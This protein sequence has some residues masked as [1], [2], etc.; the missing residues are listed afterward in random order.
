MFLDGFAVAGYRSF[1]PELQE[2]KNLRKINMFV[3]RNNSGKSNV[4]RFA[5][6]LSEIKLGGAYT[7]FDRFLDYNLGTSSGSI[8]AG[9]QVKAGPSYS[10]E[11]FEAMTSV[12]PD[13]GSVLPEYSEEFWITFDVARPHEKR[14]YPIFG[15]LAAGI[16]ANV[17]AREADH[18]TSSHLKYSGGDMRKKADD[19]AEV[20]LRKFTYE[21]SVRC[22]DA[23]RR[24]SGDEESATYSG[25]GLIRRLR[26]L[27]N[28]KLEDYEASTEKFA[29]INNFIQDLTGD[30]EAKME[31][32]AESEEIYIHL[33]GRRL[34]LD[35]LGTGIHQLVI[36]AS[37]VTIEENCVF[38]IEEPEIHLHPSLQKKLIN[39]IN[40]N[41]NNQYLIATHSN[42]F[43]DLEGVGVYHCYLSEGW[44][45]CEA[46]G[47]R[48]QGSR[49]LSDLGYRASD[50]LQA[51]F[52]VWVEGPSDRVL[53]RH[54][55]RKVAP[56]LVEGV[57]YSLMFYGGRL[58]SHLAFDDADVEEFI[59]LCRLNTHAAIIMD[60]DLEAAG[61]KLGRTK[62][63]VKADFEAVDCLTWVTAGRTIENYVSFPLLA[64]AYE[65]V[66]G[67]VPEEPRDYRYSDLTR[68]GETSRPD[69][70]ALARQVASLEADLEILD[71]AAQIAD[72]AS[73][74]RA[75][76]A[77]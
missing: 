62:L 77:Y 15:D 42:A 11:V 30:P 18:I 60:S 38:C 43:F 3:G 24:I 10:S 54:W 50:L 16:V 22:V 46:V 13:W 14:A 7:K 25:G 9:F 35:S 19:I 27:Q 23:F 65:T 53:V 39:Y 26:H 36:L 63:R 48:L 28:P 34:P 55:L 66:H 32:P 4:L 33:D 1:G 21:L 68:I 17:N 69:K 71:L 57:H 44:T 8:Q 41:T 40:E 64:Q 31:I 76:N 20:I 51:N 37:A 12:L 49:V 45:V 6:H 52:I 5:K 73:R 61:G 59:Q 70:V 58:L 56:D 74:I 29:R 75:A 72:L 47:T 67:K 2:F